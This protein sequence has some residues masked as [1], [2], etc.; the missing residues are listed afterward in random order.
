MRASR[1]GHTSHGGK[2]A[3]AFDDLEECFRGL[4]LGIVRSDRHFDA[5]LRMVADREIDDLAIDVD[6]SKGDR[7]VFFLNPLLFEESGETRV[8]DVVLGDD[9]RA[10]SIAV[11]S[12]HDS[13]TRGTAIRAQ[14]SGETMRQRANKG[15]G[16]V[17][18]RGVHDHIRRLVDDG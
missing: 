5:I 6:S 14:L 3:K 9:N 10:A 15:S 8:S 7:E 13:R 12:M 2:S 18:A 17:S 11:E 16:P 1:F 4:R